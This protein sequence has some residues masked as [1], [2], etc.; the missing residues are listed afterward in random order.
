[1]NLVTGILSGLAYGFHGLGISA[2][3]KP[4]ASELGL[5]RAV[6]SFAAGIASLKSGLEFPL[7]GWLADRFGPKWII[8]VGTCLMGVGLVLMNFITSAWGYYL[9]WGVIIGTGHNLGFTIAVD[10]VLTNWFVS[11][12]G[13]AFGVR[14]ALLGIVGVIVLPLVTWLLTAQ[15][16]RVTCLIWAAVIFAGA[17]LVLYFVKQN[18]PEYYGLLPDGATVE[19]GSE[20]DID[21]MIDKGVEYA[22]SFQETEFTIR[23]AMRTRA[24][25]M[26]TT[27]W[28]CGTIVSGGF[29]LHCIPF[30]T[31]MGI[32][33]IVAGGMMAMMVF[34]SV[35]SRFLGG[36]LADRIRKDHLRFLLA[37]AFLFQA[38]GIT[39][40][41]LNP[42]IAM[43]YVFLILFGFGSGAG[44]PLDIIIRGRY[45][46][47]K[48]YGSIQGTSEIFVAPLSL[49]APVCTGWVYDTY[50]SYTLAFIL[51][52]AIA[53]FAFVLM[54]LLRPPKPPAHITDIRQFM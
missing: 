5:S 47:R 52:A 2:L 49:L 3:F 28:A 27:A 23:Q 19:S 38:V 10:K 43:V 36:F 50:G 20:A 15:G 4:I 31:D 48:A 14:F 42:T 51:F 18:R 37:G 9:A 34:F 13:L 46:G 1:M 39:A 35:P 33:P 8:F 16:W 21:A 26:L 54:C 17:P 30:L 6:A 53:A 40:F 45:F 22:A 25:W 32:D 44:T 11:K 12:R 29:V 24:Y 41:L 7:T